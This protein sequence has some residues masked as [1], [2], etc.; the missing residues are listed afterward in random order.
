VR[1]S[2]GVDVTAEIAKVVLGAEGKAKVAFKGA[3][4]KGD[5]FV[6]RNQDVV[7]FSYPVGADLT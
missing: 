4:K 6:M 2:R 5:L 3:V 7:L 1:K